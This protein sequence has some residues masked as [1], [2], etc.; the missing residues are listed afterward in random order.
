MRKNE[1]RYISLRIRILNWVEIISYYFDSLCS[2]L[3]QNKKKRYKFTEEE[4]RQM[5]GKNKRLREI[6][7]GGRG[8]GRGIGTE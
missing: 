8:R 4:K 1:S 3:S 2:L 5:R 7:V 6:R